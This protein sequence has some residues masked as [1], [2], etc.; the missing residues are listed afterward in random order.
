MNLRNSYQSAM[1]SGF[2]P[3]ACG[4]CLAWLFWTGTALRAAD[5]VAVHKS[6]ATK[7]LM[8]PPPPPEIP[9]IN[10]QGEE[11]LFSTLGMPLEYMSKSDLENL[12]K[13]L[14][15]Q[16]ERLKRRVDDRD[17]S[18]KEQKDRVASFEDLFKEGVVSKRELDRA[19]K[20]LSELEDH[21]ADLQAHLED[22]QTDIDRVRKRLAVLEK[23][24][25]PKTAAKAAVGKRR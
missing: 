4:C 12:K 5:E 18:L 16:A 11:G 3:I 19:H 23:K 22:T 8:V 20:D 2:L 6:A 1:P 14:E 10:G 17:Q 13:R 24:A 9:L 21:G 15:G 7:K 25:A